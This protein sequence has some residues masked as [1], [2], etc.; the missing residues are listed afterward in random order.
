MPKADR[1]KF[2]EQCVTQHSGNYRQYVEVMSGFRYTAGNKGLSRNPVS[3][4][5]GPEIVKLM[6]KHK[7][8]I[9]QL[10]FRLGTSQ[11]R[12]RQVRDSGLM[13]PL[14][15]RDWIQ[16]IT[17]I[18]VGPIPEKY[19]VHNRQEEGDCCFCGYPLYICDTAYEYV[20]SMFCSI[21]CCRK[22]RNW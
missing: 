9:E 20:G 19:Q 14:A 5:P 13:D 17:G 12:V 4:L 3:S 7:M 1:R 22:S 21:T 16:A 18:D 6:R 2:I 11:K 15:I 8:T 10:A